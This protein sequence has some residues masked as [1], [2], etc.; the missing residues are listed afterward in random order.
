MHTAIWPEIFDGDVKAFFT[1]K[2]V[3]A[4]RAKISAFFAIDADSI[5]MPLQKHTDS[6]WFLS[7]ERIPITA[8]AVVTRETG[9]LIGVQVADCVPVLLYDGRKCA[10]GAVH[11]G[12]KGT[13]L[14]ILKKTILLMVERFDSDP[15]DIRL[16]FG[17]SI[18]GHCYSVDTAVKDAVVSGTGP[19]DYAVAKNGKYFLDLTSANILQAL[20]VGILR[21]NIWISTECTYCNPGDFHSF[22]YHGNYAG[23]QGGFIGIF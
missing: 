5:C 17:P 14:T 10:I 4:D 23:R 15:K 19:G 2:S 12:W 22:R 8:D 21:E 18:R 16:A 9:V 1:R 11:A 20:S 13:S 7:G 6:I 3:G